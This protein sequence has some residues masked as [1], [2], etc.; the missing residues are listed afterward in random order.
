MPGIF[1]NHH[2]RICLLIFKEKG[3]GEEKREEEKERGSEGE[4]QRE[5][6]RHI[7]V[8]EKQ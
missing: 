8:R 4:R 1:F 7:D 2:L 6:E 3:R 5:S